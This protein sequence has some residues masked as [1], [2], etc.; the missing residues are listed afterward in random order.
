MKKLINW[1]FDIYKKYKEF[2]NYLICGGLAT[3]LNIGVFTVLNFFLGVELYQVSNVISI[4]A[5]VFFQYFTNRFFV[6]ERKEQ[7]R[8]EVWSEFVKFMSARAVTALLDIGI[9]FVGVSLSLINEIIM[10]IFTQVVVIILNYIFSKFLVFTSKK[11]KKKANSE[12]LEES[13]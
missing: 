8:K 7:T 2:W 11:V 1:C 4:L 6:F 13:R 12:S 10:K 5:A 3:V 9:M